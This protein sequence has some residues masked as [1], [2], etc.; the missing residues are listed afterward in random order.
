LDKIVWENNEDEAIHQLDI[1]QRLRIKRGKIDVKI[2]KATSDKNSKYDL[3]QRLNSGG[4]RLTEQEIRTCI[5]IMENE[6][7][8]NE[9]YAMSQNEDFRYCLPITERA[10]D[11]QAYLEFIVRFIV[12]RHGQIEDMGR[13][14][15]EYLTES[16]IKIMKDLEFSIANEK[17]VFDRFFQ[18]LNTSTGEN[19]FK[20]YNVEKDAFQGPPTIS[21]FETI[22]PAV[23]KR[24]DA[25][26]KVTPDEFRKKLIQMHSHDEYKAA[27]RRR[28]TDRYKTLLSIGEEIFGN[29]EEEN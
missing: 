26:L 20:L 13:G 28:S 6:N 23:S 1:P 24:L 5:I 16:I 22:V 3:F 7:F 18:Y 17:N 10:K 12:S 2:L 11:E 9:L 19:S 14:L 15:H 4:T 25:Y 8:Y 29:N 27:Y 21:A